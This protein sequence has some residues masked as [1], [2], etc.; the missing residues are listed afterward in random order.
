MDVCDRP[1][2]EEDFVFAKVVVVGIIVVVVAMVGESVGDL[3]G[4]W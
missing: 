3:D 4:F 2:V 1:V